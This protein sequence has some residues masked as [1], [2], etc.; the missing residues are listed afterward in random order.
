MLGESPD[1]AIHINNLCLTQHNGR[2]MIEGADTAVGPGEKVI[3][4]GE[5]GTGKST[6]IRAMAGLWPWG[7]GQILRPA[8]A[9]IA[10]MPQRPY[11]PLGTLRHALTYPAMDIDAPDETLAEALR[12]CGLSHLIPRLNEEDNWDGI[13]SGGEKQRIAFARL[14]VNPP[15]IVIMDEA[16]SALDEETQA[17]MMEF[18]RTDLA[19]A[20]VLSVTHRPGLE[21]FFEREIKL[22]RE[23]GAPARTFERRYPRLRRMWQRVSRRPGPRPDPGSEAA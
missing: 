2:L 12:R 21:E 4:K 7:S 16:T 13:L 20:T 8:N 6:L 15:D 5:S 3:V 23:G 19:E 10:F 17:R 11:L 18:L 22:V 14:L 1:H 9:H